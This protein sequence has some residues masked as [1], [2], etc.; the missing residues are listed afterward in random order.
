MLLK[1]KKKIT[2]KTQKKKSH[3]N[4]YVDFSTNN[5]RIREREWWPALHYSF[6]FPK[7]WTAILPVFIIP[8]NNLWKFS[9]RYWQLHTIKNFRYVA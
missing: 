6:L 8:T 9:L 5:K 2:H 7:W 3:S 1:K 4:I